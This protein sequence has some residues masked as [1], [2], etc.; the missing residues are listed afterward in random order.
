MLFFVTHCITLL[1]E[2]DNSFDELYLQSKTTKFNGHLE[3]E[4]L[5]QVNGSQKL[6]KSEL[7]LHG[8]PRKG[9]GE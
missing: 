3:S 5:D 9:I 1:I 7:W 6:I 2:K 4:T 8:A